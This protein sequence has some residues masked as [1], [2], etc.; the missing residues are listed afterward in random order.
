MPASIKHLSDK[1]VPYNS[2]LARW[3][4]GLYYAAALTKCDKTK[5]T[6]RVCFEDGSEI[7]VSNRDVH[8]QLSIDQLSE[9]EDIVCCICDDGNSEAPNEIILC[10]VCQQG[11]H[12]K[13]HLP[14]V[15]SSKLDASEDTK[16]HKDWFC[17]T[18]SYILNQ[19]NRA[20]LSAAAA[21]QQQQQKPKQQP[22]QSQSQS[23]SPSP[24]PSP[25][26]SQSQSQSQPQPQPQAA[27][28]AKATASPVTP[29][30]SKS[31]Q[32]PPAS[33]PVVAPKIAA[34]SE[35]RTPIVPRQPPK[36]K[37]APT[38]SQTQKAAAVAAANIGSSKS[39]VGQHQRSAPYYP[40]SNQARAAVASS[41]STAALASMTASSAL[42]VGSTA[43]RSKQDLVKQ[44][45]RVS[46]QQAND[47]HGT[48]NDSST[49]LSPPK[50]AVRKSGINF[51]VT[52]VK[53]SALPTATRSIPS[54]GTAHNGPN[55][56]TT[57]SA[58]TTISR[59]PATIIST[60]SGT[61]SILTSPS[62]QPSQTSDNKGIVQRQHDL[63]SAAKPVSSVTPG[64]MSAADAHKSSSSSSS[65]SSSRGGDSVD[66][67][68]KQQPSTATTKF[69][70]SSDIVSVQSQG[71]VT[72]DST[73][74]STSSP[75]V[76][77]GKPENESVVH[78]T[79]EPQRHVSDSPQLEISFEPSPDGSLSSPPTNEQDNNNLTTNGGGRGD[80]EKNSTSATVIV[81]GSQSG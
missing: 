30:P 60:Q 55:K 29:Q 39:P 75:K 24:S 11:Y 49:V 78:S 74:S 47:S 69:T 20:K 34:N 35:T 44:S 80:E 38:S 28:A 41:S 65:S 56:E 27:Q 8:I 79:S 70:S 43:G 2:L 58:T 21:Q 45:N 51:A 61:L 22:Q 13:C 68:V 50:H 57:T 25:S 76:T 72:N 63:A 7:W 59:T 5:K 4:D 46:Q 12:Q 15:D 67:C 77:K 33:V 23:P 54:P 64:N 32:P 73:T 42:V 14:P 9:D 10:D 31:R 36:V 37:Q 40:L 3:T 52:P 71:K 48:L 17:A 16:D 19:T 62:K 26:Q 1:K 81:G 66:G 53:Q 6:C 18:C